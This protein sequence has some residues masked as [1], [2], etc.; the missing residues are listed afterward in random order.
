MRLLSVL[1]LVAS[2]GAALPAAAQVKLQPPKRPALGLAPIPGDPAPPFEAKDLEGR[3]GTFRWDE[4][5]AT[6]VHF[7]NVSCEPCR[8]DMPAIERLWAEEGHRGFR[9]VGVLMDASKPDVARKFLDEIGIRYGIYRGDAHVF[10][11]WGGVSVVPM[12]FLVS[13]D[14]KILRRYVG[15]DAASVAALRFDVLA[16][17]D[18]KPLGPPPAVAPTGS[19]DESP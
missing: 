19:I 5:N 8:L 1:A 16:A 6:L 11:A 18:G 4:M 13:K 17:L 15:A 12:A 3:R 7:F 10:A 2:L 9:V 14:G